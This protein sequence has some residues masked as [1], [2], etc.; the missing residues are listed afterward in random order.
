[1]TVIA[2]SPTAISATS[3]DRRFLKLSRA[4]ARTPLAREV[5]DIFI[6]LTRN[7]N[8]A[9]TVINDDSC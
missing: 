9:M 1:M 8:S 2:E 4:S 5:A 7:E 6:P 3:A